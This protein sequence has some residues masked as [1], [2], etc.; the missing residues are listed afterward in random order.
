MAWNGS[1]SPLFETETTTVNAHFS[2]SPTVETCNKPVSIQVRFEPCAYMTCVWLVL[3]YRAIGMSN[4]LMSWAICNSDL[5]HRCS[6]LSGSFWA[7]LIALHIDQFI[8]SCNQ[9][10]RYRSEQ[11]NLVPSAASFSK[12]SGA[13]SSMVATKIPWIV[14]RVSGAAASC[15]A[16][17]LLTMTSTTPGWATYSH[18]KHNNTIQ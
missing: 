14:T 13:I 3:M 8:V 1:K 2:F 10:W 16:F 12:I 9:S 5:S 11:W 15:N 17:S 6:Q 4:L 18:I 7:A